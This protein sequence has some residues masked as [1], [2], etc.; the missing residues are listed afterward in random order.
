MLRDGPAK[1]D[2]VRRLGSGYYCSQDDICSI[3]IFIFYYTIWEDG[4]K[5]T[6]GTRQ[7]AGA[8]VHE[9]RLNIKTQRKEQT[10]G[11]YHDMRI[12]ENKEM[13]GPGHVPRR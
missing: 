3:F 2:A 1:F 12:T 11:L 6:C 7:G 10:Y 4:K 13:T 9:H 8:L 5:R